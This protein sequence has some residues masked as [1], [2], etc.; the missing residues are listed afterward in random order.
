V[1]QPPAGADRAK[2][3]HPPVAPVRAQVSEPPPEVPR[4]KLTDPPEPVSEPHQSKLTDPP[5]PAAA[6]P[7]PA[8]P[9]LGP[10]RRDEAEDT[11]PPPTAQS[12]PGNAPAPQ[13]PATPSFEIAPEPETGAA[14]SVGQDSSRTDETVPGRNRRDEPLS[15]LPLLVS[16]A[17]IFVLLVG[18][19]VTLAAND[20]KGTV[21]MLLGLGAISVGGQLGARLGPRS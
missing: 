3:S 1:S 17:G 4:S 20:L 18:A 12:V 10:P 6:A 7:L 21:I 14:A 19:I 5:E 11:I 8:M 9:P 16:G 15:Q 2:V 13:P